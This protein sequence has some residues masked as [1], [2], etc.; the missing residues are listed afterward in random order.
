MNMWDHFSGSGQ[1]CN[2]ACRGRLAPCVH[3]VMPKEGAGGPRKAETVPEAGL[4]L[5]KTREGHLAGCAR[6]NP[7]RERIMETWTGA[8]QHWPCST[9]GALLAASGTPRSGESRRTVVLYTIPEGQKESLGSLSKRGEN[10]RETVTYFE[11]DMPSP[12]QLT[13][14]PSTGSQGKEP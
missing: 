3:I 10:W 1:V 14:S 7:N 2:W 4:S 8:F 6:R 11:T 5:G 13:R 9:Q 12:T